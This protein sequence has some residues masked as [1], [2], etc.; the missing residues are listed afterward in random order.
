M[1]VYFEVTEKAAN[2]GLWVKKATAKKLTFCLNI[3]LDVYIVLAL[4]HFIANFEY[5]TL[6][7]CST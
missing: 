2:L 3:D 6:K 5:I 7:P 1:Q 4:N